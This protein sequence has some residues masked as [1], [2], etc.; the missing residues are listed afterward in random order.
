MARLTV[1][2]FSWPSG[3]SCTPS[4]LR[5]RCQGAPGHQTFTCGGSSEETRPRPPGPAPPGQRPGPQQIANNGQETHNWFRRACV[6]STAHF[7]AAQWHPRAYPRM[8]RKAPIL[9]LGQAPRTGSPPE[10]APEGQLVL[11]GIPRDRAPWPGHSPG[12]SPQDSEVLPWAR[13]APR[14]GEL[15][16]RL[17]GPRHPRDASQDGVHM[18]RG[19][20]QDG[21]SP[22]LLPPGARAFPWAFRDGTQEGHI[23][24]TG[25]SPWASSS[26]D[27][28]AFRVAS[29]RLHGVASESTSHR[30][31]VT[32]NESH[33]IKK[34]HS[35]RA[36]Q[37]ATGPQGRGTAL[38]S[39]PKRQCRHKNVLS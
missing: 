30:L 13:A 21:E 6:P 35:Y 22:G 39:C 27:F 29:I 19:D 7:R 3:A 18:G 34:F 26:P 38:L 37:G 32:Y 11:R 36:P 15:G 5:G 9:P 33:K 4:P 10:E 2:C 28:R 23:C 12:E 8:Q 24:G 17:Q 1:P 31:G 14:D 16:T 20:P 25:R